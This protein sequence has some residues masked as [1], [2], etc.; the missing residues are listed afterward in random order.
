[1]IKNKN[2]INKN[3]KMIGNKRKRKPKRK[4]IKEST[5]I[6]IKKIE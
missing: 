6:N 3:I 2:N 5:I 4:Y 1:M